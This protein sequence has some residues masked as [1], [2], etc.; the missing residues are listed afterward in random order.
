MPNV[1]MSAVDARIQAVGSRALVV[2]LDAYLALLDAESVTA[3]MSELRSRLD[4]NALNADYLLS[5]HSNPSFAPRYEES[6][7]VVFIEG[8]EETLE[9]LSVQAYSNKWVK[10]GGINGYKQLLG[11][12][13]QFEPSG[14]YTLILAGLTEKQA[15]IGSAVTFVL[16]THE[17]AVQHYGLDVEF[18]DATLGNL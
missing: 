4:T 11:Q 8:N 13:S 18:D 9:L 12:M 14:N 10:C 3:F 1:L 6:R 7:S 2:G 17:V 5:D 15:G 16:D